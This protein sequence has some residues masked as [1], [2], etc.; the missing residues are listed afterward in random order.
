MTP[1]FNLKED[2]QRIVCDIVQRARQLLP[3]VNCT[4]LSMDLAATHNH[5]CRLRL[6]DLLAADD[7]DFIHD[8]RG[9]Y[10][11]LNRSS[12]TLE[13]CFLP[14]FSARE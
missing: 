12:I 11:H 1:N 9:I 14:R 5:A 3:D 4:T 8:I 6:A 7:F 2:E 13:H 10:R